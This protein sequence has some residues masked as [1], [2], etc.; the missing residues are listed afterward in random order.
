MVK[1]KLPQALIAIVMALFGTFIAAQPAS[2]ATVIPVGE[3]GHACGGYKYESVIKWQGCAWASWNPSGGG[4]R[5]WFTGHFANSSSVNL[6]LSAEVG[7]YEN[8]QYHYCYTTNANTFIVPA[9][10]T[11][12]TSS[13]LCWIPRRRTAVQAAIVFTAQALSPTLQVQG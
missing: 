2:A 4:S 9:G 1:R 3:A 13:E 10:G 6:G 8:G 11:R 12:A 7:Y 5:L